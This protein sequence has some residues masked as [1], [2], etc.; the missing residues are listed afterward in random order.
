MSERQHVADVLVGGEKLDTGER[1]DVLQHILKE[2]PAVAFLCRAADDLPIDFITENV[3]I[4]GYSPDDFRRRS[5]TL[6]ELVHPEDV[7]RVRREIAEHSALRRDRFALTFRV[8]TKDGQEHWTDCH[9]WIHRPGQDQPFHYHGIMLD[10]TDRKVLEDVLD[11]EKYFI[12][13]VFNNSLDGIAVA[14]RDG[15]LIA[16]N[17][18]IQRLFGYPTAEIRTLQE[19]LRQ[20]FPDASVRRRI[21][22]QWRGDLSRPHPPPREYEAITASGQARWFR[23]RLSPMGGDNMLLTCQDIT[24]SKRVEADLRSARDELEAR[25]ERRTRQL[26]EANSRLQQEIRERQQ[27]E[28]ALEEKQ[29]HFDNLVAHVPGAVY[30]CLYDRDWTMTYLSAGIQQLTGYAPAELLHNAR[31]TYASVIHP[32]DRD[33]VERGVRNAVQRR[34]PFLL[35]YRLER[36]DGKLLHVVEKGCPCFNDKGEATWIDGVIIDETEQTS[37][38]KRLEESDNNFKTLADNAQDGILIASGPD[39]RHVYANRRASEI[40]GY[41]TD[42]LLTMTIADLVHPAERKRLVALYTERVTGRPTPAI[43]ETV[44][45]GKHGNAIPVEITG[46]RTIW[47]GQPATIGMLRDITERKH[48]ESMLLKN[49]KTTQALLNASDDIALLLDNQLTILAAN[50]VAAQASGQSVDDLVGCSLPDCLDTLPIAEKHL[51]HVQSVLDTAQPARF[52]ILKNRR[53][54]HVRLYPAID[55]I[56]D[57]A[58]VAFFARDITENRR[59]QRDILNAATMERER[60]GRD[61]HDNLGQHLTALSLLTKSLQSKIGDP[62]ATHLA[63]E[64]ETMARKAISL[65][66]IT[67][68]GLYPIEF[69]RDKVPDALEE[70]TARAE[71]IYGIHCQTQLDQNLV[72]ADDFTAMN[73]FYITQEAVHNA[74]KYSGAT[75]IEISLTGDGDGGVLQIQD[76]GN[77]MKEPADNDSGLGIRCMQYRADIIG[78]DLSIESGKHGTTVRC[79]LPKPDTNTAHPSDD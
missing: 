12:N 18:A 36:S 41:T 30:R 25:V 43:Y 2:S 48:A 74:A 27:Y 1:C 68:Q 59:L 57:D 42:E 51:H 72:V 50:T 34:E 39:A 4:F 8:L 21:A 38:K 55:N 33:A 22:R 13:N 63:E 65:V 5:R 45:R 77:G 78:A 17:P 9:L 6:Y 7:D 60:I 66:K 44:L 35:R 76:N 37:A 31:R 62:E 47:H 54:Y 28:K 69:P 3:G 71:R 61:L 20:I 10:I 75:R 40:T 58:R 64:V 70:L 19:L 15:R 53:E 32:E 23:F 46:A 67:A 11:E 26:A 73:L 49:Q 52:E 56:N 16:V 79:R 29:Q 14:R 24:E